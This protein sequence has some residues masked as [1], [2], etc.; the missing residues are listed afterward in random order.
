[1]TDHTNLGHDVR[2]L[3]L[4][5]WWAGPESYTGAKWCLETFCRMLL[6]SYWL[7]NTLS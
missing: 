7:Q 1:M 4:G 3:A 6:Q 2:K 5:F